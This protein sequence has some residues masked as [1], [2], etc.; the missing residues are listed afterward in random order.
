MFGHKYLQKLHHLM[1]VTLKKAKG[2]ALNIG[3]INLL[4]LGAIVGSL[5]SSICIYL[6]RQHLPDF[7]TPLVTTLKIL[8][9]SLSRGAFRYLFRDLS[10]GRRGIKN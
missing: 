9:Y 2:E 4:F 3:N 10:R 7:F 8:Q 6:G 5:N 1:A